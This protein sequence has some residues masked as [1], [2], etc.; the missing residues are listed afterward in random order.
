MVV[1][2][3][4][5]IRTEIK[6]HITSEGGPYSRWYVGIAKNARERL[7]QDHGVKEKEDS[8]IIREAISD[9][10]ARKIEDYFVNTLKTSGNP[11]GGDE[12]TVFVY[13][14]WKQ[15]HTEP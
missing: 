9:D 2:D 14:Y 1:K 15:T 6:N 3:E 10:I 7:F 11:G 8:W 12:K 4:N 13:A 5:T